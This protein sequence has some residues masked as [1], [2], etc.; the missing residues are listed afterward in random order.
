MTGLYVSISPDSK[1]KQHLSTENGE[2]PLKDTTI[3][4]EL[5]A[6]TEMSF[7]KTARFTAE[8]MKCSPS[9]YRDFWNAIDCFLTDQEASAPVYAL[10]TRTAIADHISNYRNPRN[11]P[12]AMSA[13]C[14]CLVLPVSAQAFTVSLLDALCTGNP[15][16]QEPVYRLLHHM[17][18]PA[19][20]SLGTEPQLLFRAFDRYY[21]FLLQ[22]FVA[23]QYRVAKCQYCGSYFIPKTK[24]KTL[25]CDREIRDGKTCKQIAPYENHKRLA[26]ANKVIAEFDRVKGLLFRRVERA[27]CG[28]KTSPIDL[29]YE[30]YYRWLEAATDARDRFLAGEIAEEEALRIIHVPTIWELRENNSADYTLDYSCPQS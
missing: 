23:A 28:K 11:K 2:M 5:I 10:L 1:I 7:L 22:Q 13:I 27:D 18:I 24:R 21:I 30:E 9:S 26:A 3:S 14:A 6:L 19:V 25:Y 17:K 16:T 4:E 29:N 8:L 12:L 15:I 20:F